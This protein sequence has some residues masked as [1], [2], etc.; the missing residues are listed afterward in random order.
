[1]WSVDLTTVSV[2][3]DEKKPQM[4]VSEGK[5]KKKQKKHGTHQI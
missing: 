3:H 2:S 5:K 1:M 4:E